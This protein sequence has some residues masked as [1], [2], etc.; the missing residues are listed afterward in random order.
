MCYIVTTRNYKDIAIK[1]LIVDDEQLIT[2]TLEIILQCYGHK[3]T[4]FNSGFKALNTIRS[5]HFNIALID[6][7]MPEMNGVELMT[8]I[9][10]LSAR[11][12]IILMTGYGQHHPLYKRAVAAK[13]DKLLHKPFDP[14]NLIEIVKYYEALIQSTDT[15]SLE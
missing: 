10:R 15:T 3:A 13:P 6:I 14:E 5:E 8:E 1:I 2:G 12:K 9:R 4:S 11:T 7:G